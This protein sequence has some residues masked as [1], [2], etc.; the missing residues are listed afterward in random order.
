M[1]NTTE[2][3]PVLNFT[4]CNVTMKKPFYVLF[5]LM[6]FGLS[7]CKKQ[8][9]FENFNTRLAIVLPNDCECVNCYCKVGIAGND[10]RVIGAKGDKATI[11]INWNEL[12]LDLEDR[13]LLTLLSMANTPSYDSYLQWAEFEPGR[14]Y[15]WNPE[16]ETWKETGM[17]EEDQERTDLSGGRPCLIGKWAREK[18][19]LGAEETLLFNI[20]GSGVFITEDCNGNCTEPGVVKFEWM[21]NTGSQVYIEV[22]KIRD[23]IPGLVFRFNNDTTLGF[24]CTETNLQILEKQFVRQ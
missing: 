10:Y 13:P 1:K 16:K 19:P 18:C 7:S 6:F 14:N 24:D 11:E 2:K 4:N 3:K 8:Y 20:D 12:D 5:I 17:V 21:N 15:E 9:D 22:D 23:C